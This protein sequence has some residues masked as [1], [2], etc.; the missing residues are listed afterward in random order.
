MVLTFSLTI[1]YQKNCFEVILK[2]RGRD[3]SQSSLVFRC[4]KDDETE[5]RTTA[6][7][8]PQHNNFIEKVKLKTKKQKCSSGISERCLH[9]NELFIAQDDRKSECIL[10]KN[11]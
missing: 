3:T 6:L 1:L 10:T 4:S 7:I 5:R 11:L 8:N 9:S 2:Y